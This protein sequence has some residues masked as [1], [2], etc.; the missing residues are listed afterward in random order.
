MNMHPVPGL[1]RRDAGAHTIPGVW[2][3]EQ[4]FA[5]LR[6]P[7]EGGLVLATRN[8][9]ETLTLTKLPQTQ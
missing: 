3:P 6:R 4:Q 5:C 8:P 2:A 1:I 9:H 7:L